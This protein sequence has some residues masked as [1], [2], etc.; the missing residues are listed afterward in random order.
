MPVEKTLQLIDGEIRRGR[1]GKARDRMHGLLSNDPCNPA[2]RRKMG[3]IYWKL[4]MPE[5]AGR[6]WYLEEQ[7]TEDMRAACRAFEAQCGR[8]PMQILFSLK[9]RL[10]DET[11]PYRKA[12]LEKLHA[13]A[14]RKHS[15]YE[16]YRERGRS[17][18]YQSKPAKV[19][20]LSKLLPAGCLLAVIAVCVLALDGLYHIGSLLFR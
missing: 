9:Y 18:F 10:R 1:L 19:T 2:L 12:V 14:K 5:M 4:Q 11:D 15:W 6:Y 8:D 20:F 3:E 13:E 17:K 16:D 7:K